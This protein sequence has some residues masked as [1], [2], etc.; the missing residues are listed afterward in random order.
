MPLVK[1][2]TWKSV[3]Q[4]LLSPKAR[5]A[6]LNRLA[7]D[8]YC[9]PSVRSAARKA[10]T[11]PLFAQSAQELFGD[12]KSQEIT[13]ATPPGFYPCNPSINIHNEKLLCCVRVVNYR[14]ERGELTLAPGTTVHQ[15]QNFLLEL[16]PLSL[17]T[18][19][20][21]EISSPDGGLED[22]AYQ[23]MEDLRLIS[24]GGNLWV[25]FTI[26]DRH[27]SAI[28][29]MAVGQLSEDGRLEKFSV[30]DFEGYH[31]QKNWMPFVDEHGLGWVSRCDPILVLRFNSSQ[32]QAQEWRRWRPTL[33]LDLLR[34]SSQL[35]PWGQGWL[36]VVH[37]MQQRFDPFYL[38]RFVEFDS[39]FSIAA[40]TDPFYFER[41]GI[42]FCAGLCRDP[43]SD[44]LLVSLGIEDR[45]AVIGRISEKNIRKSLAPCPPNIELPSP[46]AWASL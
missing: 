34:G 4:L 6:L 37:E 42:E 26:L 15:S 35:V 40:I 32:G 30:Q 21:V 14:W 36:C 27:P 33:S 13:L 20:V 12:W 5:R 38:H 22:A 9:W 44:S 2:S 29:Q 1:T 7:L 11:L 23:G 28:A 41:L 16:N 45:K 43:H 3:P 39:A 31:P 19:Q 8:R 24:H 25:S 18:G 17:E 46:R 10:L